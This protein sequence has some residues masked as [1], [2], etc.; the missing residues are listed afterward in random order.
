MTNLREFI[1]QYKK[2][3]SERLQHVVK[4]A[5]CGEEMPWLNDIF[6]VP[7][8]CSEDCEV[9]FNYKKTLAEFQIDQDCEHCGLNKDEFELQYCARTPSACG[10]PAR[11]WK[12]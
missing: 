7:V 8:F 12:K 2:D 9:R 1:E 4:C 11:F 10:V 5:K 3:E 6:D